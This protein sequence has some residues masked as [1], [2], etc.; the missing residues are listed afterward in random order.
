[1]SQQTQEP[2]DHTPTSEASP[3]N[4]VSRETPLP[5]D[6]HECCGGGD[7]CAGI[8]RR[9][10][11]KTAGLGLVA[12]SPLGPKVPAMAGPFMRE[13]VGDD[14]FVPVDKRLSEQWLRSLYEKG[15]PRVYRGKELN[16]IGMPVGGLAAGQLYLCGDG[17]LGE[18]K[19]FNQRYF[20]GYGKENYRPR[21][22]GKPIEQGF[23]VVVKGRPLKGALCHGLNRRDFPKV[24]FV[25]EYPLGRVRYADEKYPVRVELEAFS[26]FIP[27]NA[28]DSALPATILEF[29]IENTLDQSVRA[30]LLGWLENAVCLHSRREYK[31]VLQHRSRMIDERGRTLLIHTAEPLPAESL[32][33]ENIVLADFEGGTYGEWVAEGK[34]LGEKPASG[35]IE[36]DHQ[37][38][39]AGFEG[40]GLVNTFLGGDKSVGKLKSPAFTISRKHIRFL[41]GGGSHAN[42]TCINL[43]VKEEAVRSATGQ[44]TER[45]QWHSWDVAEFAGQ[46]AH[47]E[48]VDSATGGWGHVNVDQVELSDQPRFGPSGPV[49]ELE[50]FGSMALTLDEQELYRMH[51]D[52][53]LLLRSFL[54]RFRAE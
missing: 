12:L 25:G 13:L 37:N 35:A 31:L 30:G 29:T 16:L 27:L 44:N 49:E 8:G 50:D 53:L 19:I 33:R 20:S 47:I 7:T 39:V 1:M 40:E 46:T 52:Q 4:A 6:Q 17:T 3:G 18:W 54:R 48:I 28:R 23:A 38:S 9:Q 24:E 14:H 42:E 2:S 34:A 45:L 10:F 41:I 22:P 5:P 26:P 51:R 32:E 21:L 15:G 36:K 43:I 11:L